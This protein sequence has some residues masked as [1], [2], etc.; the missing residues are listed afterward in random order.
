MTTDSSVQISVSRR[1]TAAS[2]MPLASIQAIRFVR[3][4]SEAAQARERFP[5]DAADRRQQ[6]D[7]QRHDGEQPHQDAAQEQADAGAFE[8]AGEIAEEGVAH[9]EALEPRLRERV[10]EAE[11]SV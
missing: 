10:G 5:V 2:A 11:R 7:D 8:T 4:Q 6:A 9:L 1:M 3:A